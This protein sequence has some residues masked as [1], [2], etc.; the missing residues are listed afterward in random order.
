[1]QL[2]PCHKVCLVVGGHFADLA[3]TASAQHHSALAQGMAYLD[4]EDCRHSRL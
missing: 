4:I 1:M 2:H 3:A